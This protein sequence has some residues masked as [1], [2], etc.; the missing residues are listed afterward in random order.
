M[1]FAE[2]FTP[3][4]QLWQLSENGYSVAMGLV[5]N[6]LSADASAA[7]VTGGVTVTNAP[8]RSSATT[9]HTVEKAMQTVK[10]SMEAAAEK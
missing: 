2:K 6:Q 4:A 10:E 8:Q 7:P 9:W 3:N 1:V 5:S